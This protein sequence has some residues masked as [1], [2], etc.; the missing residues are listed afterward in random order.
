MTGVL[1][2]RGHLNTETDMRT[3]RRP[4]DKKAEVRVMHP[5]QIKEHRGVASNHLEPILSHVLN[6]TGPADPSDLWPPEP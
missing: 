6:R 3:E 4:V 2:E 5:Q 1:L